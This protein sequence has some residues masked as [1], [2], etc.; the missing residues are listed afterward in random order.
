[1]LWMQAATELYDEKDGKYHFPGE[2]KMLGKEIVRTS[3]E[4]VDF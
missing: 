2:S 4:M 1:M 3:E